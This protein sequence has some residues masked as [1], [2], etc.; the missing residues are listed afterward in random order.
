[1]IRSALMAPAGSSL[2]GGLWADDLPSAVPG[3]PTTYLVSEDTG[4][5]GVQWAN[6]DPTAWTQVGYNASGE[7]T[8]VS[9]LVAPGVTRWD[10]GTTDQAGWYVRH[11][12]GGTPS[13]WVGPT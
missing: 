3:T 4:E 2:G 8:S 11:T 6:G 9:T 12:K 10:T 7:P 1:V 13:A 5:I